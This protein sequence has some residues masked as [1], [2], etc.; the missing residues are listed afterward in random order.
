MTRIDGVRLPVAGLGVLA[1]ATGI[2]VWGANGWYDDRAGRPPPRPAEGV[3]SPA[4]STPEG[5]TVIKVRALPQ[6]DLAVRH[7][8]H[9]STPMTSLSVTVPVDPNLSAGVVSARGLRLVSGG[10]EVEGRRIL[11]SGTAVFT[12]APTRSVHLRYVLSGALERAG[13]GATRA[14]ARLT[15]LDLLPDAEQG[16]AT[17]VFEGARILSLACTRRGD[18]EPVPCGTR[19]GED[20][21][22]DLPAQVAAD[23]HVMAQLDLVR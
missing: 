23:S 9:T 13:P 4:S 18:V 11:R 16:T 1:I 21:V 19:R 7:R 2:I 20:W 8:I 15:T 6:G 14:L 22:V 3:A 17:Y 5:W 12:L 10:V